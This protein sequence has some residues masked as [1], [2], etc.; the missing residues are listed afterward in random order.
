MSNV[1]YLAG[2]HQRACIVL[3]ERDPLMRIA[4]AAHLRKAGL[5][6]IEAVDSVEAL[7]LLRSGRTISLVLGDLD[8]GTE[9]VSAIRREF[10]Q[11]SLVIGCARG[12]SG[13]PHGG[14]PLAVRPYDP[15]KVVQLVKTLLSG[16]ISRN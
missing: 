15:P 6:V 16:R 7:A 9:A 4:A 12:T 14:L 8:L 1:I 11:V 5:S 13:V 3:V 2:R 10:P